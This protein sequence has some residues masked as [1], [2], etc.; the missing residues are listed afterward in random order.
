[1]IKIGNRDIRVARVIIYKP[2]LE[3]TSKSDGNNKVVKRQ[4]KKVKSKLSLGEMNINKEINIK[5]AVEIE[6]KSY[7]D[8]FQNASKIQKI[9]NIKTN[10]VDKSSYKVH[11]EVLDLLINPLKFQTSANK[12]AVRKPA[13]E[14]FVKPVKKAYVRTEL[15]LKQQIEIVDLDSQ[16]SNGRLIIYKK[17][18]V[19]LNIENCLKASSFCT[20]EYDNWKSIHTLIISKLSTRQISLKDATSLNE[21]NDII[22]RC[23]NLFNIYNPEH[24]PSLIFIKRPVVELIG[25]LVCSNR[26]NKYQYS[27]LDYEGIRYRIRLDRLKSLFDMF[28]VSSIMERHMPLL[29][30][31]VF[32]RKQKLSSS[33]IKSII[34]NIL[35]K[36]FNGKESD[37]EKLRQIGKSNIVDY[38]NDLAELDNNCYTC[39]FYHKE[40]LDVLCELIFNDYS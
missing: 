4:A 34:R 38:I 13:C 11:K 31:N 15:S 12:I 2:L 40:Y 33:L 14:W 29:L 20:E 17:V 9:S 26:N 10:L 21:I 35:W 5:K 8:D 23:D 1:M 37:L 22:A 32:F 16:G 30:S 19:N 18:C 27:F 25:K 24:I 36:I 28:D 6:A 3:S 7:K 39:F